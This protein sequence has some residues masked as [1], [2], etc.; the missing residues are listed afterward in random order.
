MYGPG[1]GFSSVL[2][3][4]GPTRTNADGSV[5]GTTYEMPV[6][7]SSAVMTAYDPYPVDTEIAS[8]FSAGAEDVRKIADN[9]AHGRGTLQIGV[10][11]NGTLKIPG[12][13]FGYQVPGFL[14]HL[15][16][17]YSLS[18]GVAFDTH[19]NVAVYGTGGFGTGAE[20]AGESDDLVVSVQG[21]DAKTVDD[22][23]GVFTNASVHG[24][25]G[26]G[27]S[28]D[29]FEGSSPDGQVYGGGVT[30]GASEGGSIQV[31]KTETLLYDINKGQWYY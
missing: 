12:T 9:V 28:L 10:A 31:S 8:I 2:Y 1:T 16:V 5:E 13:A 20:G 11:A 19:G 22:L 18:G 23:K 3:V 7:D 25:D 21:S 6:A 27:G 24:G 14:T 30:F 15:G 4:E 29:G 26:I 17:S